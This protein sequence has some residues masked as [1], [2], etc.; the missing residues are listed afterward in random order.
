M[1]VAVSDKNSVRSVKAISL[2]LQ[3]AARPALLYAS[4]QFPNILL[5]SRLYLPR[6]IASTEF[7]LGVGVVERHGSDL[8][9]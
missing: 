9:H 1:R 3:F 8:T 4:V 2:M 5:I 6:K 7:V